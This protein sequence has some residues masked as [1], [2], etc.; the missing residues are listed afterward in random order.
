MNFNTYEEASKGMKEEHLDI[1]DN[2]LL[3]VLTGQS[4]I[5]IRTH[6]EDRVVGIC[7]AIN[8]RLSTDFTVLHV[9]TEAGVES[10]LLDALEHEGDD[11]QFRP[12][13]T[14][15]QDGESSA[16]TSLHVR[17]LTS[18]LSTPEGGILLV[19]GA[20]RACKQTELVRRC[21][22]WFNCR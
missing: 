17:A 22:K 8:S 2:V 18:F 10:S 15:V 9:L 11:L 12:L 14:A 13:S 21:K 5:H 3:P 20:D 19:L 16:Q 7:E 6:E 1:M 4:V